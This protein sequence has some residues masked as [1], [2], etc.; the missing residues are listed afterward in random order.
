MNQ[1]HI[2]KYI[3]IN[4]YYSLVLDLGLHPSKSRLLIFVKQVYPNCTQYDKK[5]KLGGFLEKYSE[6]L[7]CASFTS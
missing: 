3:L 1:I 2:Q 6:A 5:A 7:Y 4:F